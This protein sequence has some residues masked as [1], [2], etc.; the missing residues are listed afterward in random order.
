[1]QAGGAR[2]PAPSGCSEETRG[3]ASGCVGKGQPQVERPPP[4]PAGLGGP[5]RWPSGSASG[6]SGDPFLTEPGSC[7]HCRTFTIRRR[8]GQACRSPGTAPRT[9]VG[10]AA[11]ASLGWGRT[12]PGET[13]PSGSGLLVG[14]TKTRKLP[15]R[16]RGGVGWGGERGHCGAVWGLSHKPSLKGSPGAGS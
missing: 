10:A 1:M 8:C 7:H 12:G 6:R 13:V 3:S 16:T 2:A 14:K 15:P 9:A 11:L 4:V 5:A